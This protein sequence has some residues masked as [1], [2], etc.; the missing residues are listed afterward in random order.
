MRTCHVVERAVTQVL[1]TA[2]HTRCRM[3]F[4]RGH[5][6]DLRDPM[7]DDAGHVRTGLPLTEE[8]CLTIDIHVIAGQPAEGILN[9]YD[10]NSGRYKRLIAPNAISIAITSEEKMV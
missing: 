7:R 8:I 6:D 9:A 10:A 2:G 1:E 3:I 4:H 5:V